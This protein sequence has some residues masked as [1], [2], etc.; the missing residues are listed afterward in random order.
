MKADVEAYIM[1][2]LHDVKCLG[3]I[4]EALIVMIPLNSYLTYVSFDERL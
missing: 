2:R 3:K 1:T 4:L